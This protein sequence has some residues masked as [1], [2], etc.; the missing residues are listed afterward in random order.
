MNS[1]TGFG[2]IAAI[3]GVP[4]QNQGARILYLIMALMFGVLGII[5]ELM[6]R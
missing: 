6:R 4:M 3:L 2:I 5:R 1:L